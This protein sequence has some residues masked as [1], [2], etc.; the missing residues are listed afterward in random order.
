M[1]E[2][3]IDEVAPDP[4][5]GTYPPHC[6]G[7]SYDPGERRGAEVIPAIRP[8]DPIVLGIQ[9]S[10]Q[11]ARSV[12][13]AGGRG[14]AADLHPEEPLRRLRW[15]R[16]DRGLPR[17]AHRG[18]RHGP[19]LRRR[20][21]RPRRLRHAGRRRHAGPRLPRHRPLRRDLGP[22]PGA[23]GNDARP[24]GREGQGHHPGRVCGRALAAHRVSTTGCYE[25]GL[26]RGFTFTDQSPELKSLKKRLPLYGCGPHA[27]GAFDT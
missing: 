20:R 8:V 18:A 6:M 5:A 14:E 7:R 12:A 4:L 19:R 15:E 1:D 10:E 24:V 21:G 16:I 11:E 27:M 17:G 9:A 3:E 25:I 13:G 26:L 23:R 22:R 2:D